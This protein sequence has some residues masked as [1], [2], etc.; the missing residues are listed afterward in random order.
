MDLEVYFDLDQTSR[1]IVRFRNP[2]GTQD[3]Q[4]NRAL[5]LIDRVEFWTVGGAHTQI[6]RAASTVQKQR[7]EEVSWE[8][9]TTN[10]RNMSPM[11]GCG[12]GGSRTNLGEVRRGLLG[13]IHS[14]RKKHIHTVIYILLSYV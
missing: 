9:H 12:C 13:G 8:E 1:S 2:N 5:C 6:T 14:K 4:I 11:F 3:L 10:I 7:C